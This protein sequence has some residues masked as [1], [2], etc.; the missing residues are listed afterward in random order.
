LDRTIQKKKKIQK[1]IL[2]QKLIDFLKG[3]FFKIIWFSNLSTLK[4]IPETRRALKI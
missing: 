4:V 3:F 2:N 1:K